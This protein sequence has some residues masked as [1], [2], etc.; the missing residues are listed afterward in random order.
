[1]IKF[2][3]KTRKEP[4]QAMQ[5]YAPL[6]AITLTLLS[7]LILFQILGENPL[8]AYKAFFFDPISDINGFSELLLK[9]SP[10][11]LI[12]LGLT[13]CYRAN[14]W[15][16][17]AEG[18]MYLGG[19]FATGIAIHYANSLGNWTLV[20]MILASALGGA[21]WASI[22]ALCRAQF[23]TN[24]I[25]V[26]L[27][28]TYVA[29]LLVKFLVYGPWKDPMGNN[30]PIT[31][32]F[33]DEALFTPLALLGWSFW[34]GTRLNTSV[35]ITLFFIPLVW[36]YNEKLFAGFKNLVVGIAP[37]AAKYVGFSEKKIIWIVLILSGLIS[38]IAGTTEVAGP[39]GQLNDKW[40]PGYGFTAI[41]VATLGR[42]KVSGVVLASLL[43]ALLYLGGESV[44]V[45]MQL[46]KS[47]S[48]VFQ[49]LLLLYLLAC[50]VLI[51]YEIVMSR[52]IGGKYVP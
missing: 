38:G 49:G 13:I 27:M 17:G 34:D 52:K 18:Q 50:D 3:L 36:L 40:T 43:M 35:F 11:C 24:E 7:G 29:D 28:L 37:G 16:I 51:N 25:L 15:N 46:P 10:L 44:Q 4:N 39:I 48:Q 8:I 6:I 1:M 12:A 19:I 22:T 2:Q 41:I 47:V 26:S 42:L 21:I 20:V 23:N 32:S 45:T 33:A 31:I 30:F 14:I 5:I 9:A